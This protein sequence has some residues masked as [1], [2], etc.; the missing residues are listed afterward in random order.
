MDSL[1]T[2]N[3]RTA[4]DREEPAGQEYTVITIPGG[5]TGDVKGVL[6][7]IRDLLMLPNTLSNAT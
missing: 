2:Y 5:L 4:I 1:T 7:R 6:T 3:D